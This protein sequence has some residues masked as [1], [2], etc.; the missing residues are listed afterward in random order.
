VSTRG[1]I[2]FVADAKASIAYNHFDSY[3]SALGGKMLAWLR[4]ADLDAAA[5]EVRALRVVAP[6]SEPTDAD[7]A[8]LKDFYNYNPGA[9]ARSERPTWYQLLRGIQGEP[10]LMLK[11]GVIEDASTFPADSLFAEW[12]YVVDFDAQTFEVY[13]GFQRAP[14]SEGRFATEAPNGDGYFPVRLV[15]GWPLKSLPSAAEFDVAFG[16][17][18]DE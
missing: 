9:D 10:E 17:F 5:A 12:G 8:A 1:F 11:A 16:D 6:G 3:P 18:D 2:G 15:A 4:G 13:K 14:H 7:I